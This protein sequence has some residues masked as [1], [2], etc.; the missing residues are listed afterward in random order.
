[1]VVASAMA[2]AVFLPVTPHRAYAS[3]FAGNC[4]GISGPL[5]SNGGIVVVVVVDVNDGC[6][7]RIPSENL[8]AV[9]YNLTVVNTVGGGFLSVAPTGTVEGGTSAVYWTGPGQ[10]VPNGGVVGVGVAFEENGFIRVDAGPTGSTNFFVD[11]TGHYTRQ[12]AA[13][14]RR[15]MTS[16]ERSHA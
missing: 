14:C 1:M 9:T 10:I 13:G 6:N 8:V 12:W 3:R 2:G 11:F 4:N 16:V 15:T 7:A 5:T